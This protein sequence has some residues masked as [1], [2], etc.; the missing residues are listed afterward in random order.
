MGGMS[1]MAGLSEASSQAGGGRL[2]L[3]KSNLRVLQVDDIS[4]GRRF[5]CW[6]HDSYMCEYGRGILT[7]WGKNILGSSAQK[8]PGVSYDWSVAP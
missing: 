1:P 7:F 4:Y 3:H 8:W 6:Q 2:G 5:I